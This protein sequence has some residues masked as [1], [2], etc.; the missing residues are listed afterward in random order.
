MRN[1]L[2]VFM[3]GVMVGLLLSERQTPH[4]ELRMVKG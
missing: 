4:H 2:I 3:F 1:Y